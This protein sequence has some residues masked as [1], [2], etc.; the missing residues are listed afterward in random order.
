MELNYLKLGEN[1]KKYRKRLGYTQKKLAE[2]INVSEQ[3][4]SHIE[5]MHTKPS[6]EVIVDIANA[7]QTDVNTLLADSLPAARKDILIEKLLSAVSDLG[8]DEFELVINVSD[9]IREYSETKKKN[10]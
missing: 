10:R 4:I 8:P 5:T 2:L 1:I 6:L 3:H 7:L 9:S